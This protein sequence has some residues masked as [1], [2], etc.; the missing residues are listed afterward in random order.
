MR[1]VLEARQHQQNCFI[2]LT[3]DDENLPKSKS[4]D[5]THLQKFFKRLRKQNPNTPLRYYAC[6]EYGDRTKRAHYHACLFGM[7]FADKIEFR[8]IGD[9]TLYISE[10]LNKLWGN[11]LTSIGN[12]TFESAAYC[13]RYVLKKRLSVNK[14]RHSHYYLEEETGELIPV[15]QPFAAMSLRPAIARQWV[16]RSGAD[17]YSA[18]KDFLVMRGK[19]LKP[20]KYFD[21]I[22][23]KI[24]PTRIERIK[25][26]RKEKRTELTIAELRTHEK[27]TRARIIN[28]KQV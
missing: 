27:I 10:E 20:P 23:D 28:R 19:K 9:N 14:Q 5:K 21:N 15:E 18:D 3:Y 7:D 25:K 13:A 12:L 11:G 2:T 24:D 4:L 17:I 26:K 8:K 1:C 6:G 16:E 22:Y